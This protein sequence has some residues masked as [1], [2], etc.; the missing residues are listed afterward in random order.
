MPCLC[1]TLHAVGAATAQHVWPVPSGFSSCLAGWVLLKRRDVNGF[2]TCAQ[3]RC[4]FSTILI[5]TSNFQTE[6]AQTVEH[7][8]QPMLRVDC[9]QVHVLQ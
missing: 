1:L 3:A 9:W 5:C 4:G 8:E 7:V 2:W 6:V